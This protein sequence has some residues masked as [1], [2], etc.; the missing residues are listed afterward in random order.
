MDD[1]V[2]D[3]A[4][5]RPPKID[6]DDI[7]RQIRAGQLPTQA[8]TS[9]QSGDFVAFEKFDH[10]AAHSELD[11]DPLI[12]YLLRELNRDE[13]LQTQIRIELASSRL[14]KLSVIGTLWN[15]LRRQLHGLSIFYVRR[16]AN[17]IKI[18][19]QHLLTVLNLSL[20]QQQQQ[21]VELAKLKQRVADLEIQLAR[22][23]PQG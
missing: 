1:S 21:A 10:S 7:M 17:Q 13:L 12:R 18:R 19:N 2:T 16:L 20:Q 4:G 8:T 15:N 23:E 9:P 6:V 3:E 5:I 14:D 11:N 22:G